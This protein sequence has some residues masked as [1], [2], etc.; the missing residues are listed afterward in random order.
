ME[1]KT[2]ESGVVIPSKTRDCEECKE[3]DAQSSIDP[4]RRFYPD[5]K[6]DL[7]KDCILS[8]K[9]IKEF[10]ANLNELKIK[11]PNNFGYML[12]YYIV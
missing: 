5:Y 6:S 4:N 8:T 12:P 11:P 7:C 3:I 10:E 2:F 9:Q 1:K